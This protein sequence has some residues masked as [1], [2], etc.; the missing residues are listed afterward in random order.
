MK[1]IGILGL[2]MEID[3]GV[4]GIHPDRVT[5]FTIFLNRNLVITLASRFTRPRAHLVY[6]GTSDYS[7][8]RISSV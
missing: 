3:R 5:R 4:Q 1:I 7:S 6:S 2:P 8:A